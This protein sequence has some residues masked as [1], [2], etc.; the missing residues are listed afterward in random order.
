MSHTQN[1]RI[2]SNKTSTHQQIKKNGAIFGGDFRIRTKN[3]KIR[4]ETQRGGF[5][6]VINVAHDTKMMYGRTLVARSFTKRSGSREEYEEHEGKHEG[7]HERIT[8]PTRNS[9]TC[10]RSTST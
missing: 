5:E 8:Q 9:H 3:N 2:K 6:I 10:A 4:L 7:K 1:S